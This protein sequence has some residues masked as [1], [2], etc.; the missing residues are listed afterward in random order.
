MMSWEL[1]TDASDVWEHRVDRGE[2]RACHVQDDG[3]LLVD[4]FAAREGILEYRTANGVRRELVTAETLDAAIGGLGRAP[5]TLEHPDPRK[6]PQGVTPDNVEELVVGDTDGTVRMEKGGFVRVE[7]AVRRR[8]A[9]DA[10]RAGK[11]ELSPGYSVRLDPTPGVHPVYG[12]YDAVQVERRYNHLAIVDRARGGAEVRLRAD[13]SAAGVATTVI[14]SGEARTSPPIQGRPARGATVNP[15]LLQALHDLDVRVDGVSTDEAAIALLARV[16]HERAG[17]RADAEKTHKSALATETARADSEKARADK[18][19]AELKA[20]RD[21]EKARVDSEQRTRLDGI[22]AKLGID[23]KAHADLPALRRAIASKHLGS[24]VRADASDDYVAA[25]VDLAEKA[26][27]SRS[28]GRKAGA[29]AWSTGNNPIRTPNRADA[30][31]PAPRSSGSVFARV[32][33]G[34]DAARKGAGGGDQ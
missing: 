19:E 28:D 23:P 10:V 2:L 9:I 18:A 32:L 34:R 6:Y 26:G 14:T 16:T 1:R 25:L 20:L 12:R 22:A 29:E 13:A 21:A 31:P 24:D 7:L 30:A 17:A 5:V 33:A 3:T 27:G 4:G 8:D 15:L 11:Q